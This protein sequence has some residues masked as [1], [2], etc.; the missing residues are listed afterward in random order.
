MNL[1]KLELELSDYVAIFLIAVVVLSFVL[2]PLL[3]NG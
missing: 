2:M 1:G 3:A